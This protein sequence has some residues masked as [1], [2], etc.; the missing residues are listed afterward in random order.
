MKDASQ[1]QGT[2][3]VY[4]FPTAGSV[5]EEP[6]S[7]EHSQKFSLKYWMWGF[8]QQQIKPPW[9]SES[10]SVKCQQVIVL[11]IKVRQIQHTQDNQEA[12]ATA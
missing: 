11:R 3:W 9:A 4:R 12:I 6:E 1:M 8:K 10:S 5:V 7:W 2:N